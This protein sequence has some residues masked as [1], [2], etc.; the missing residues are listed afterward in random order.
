M[1]KIELTRGKY[2]LVDDAD[3]DFLMR[4][5]WYFNKGYAIRSG[6]RLEN[7]GRQKTI[8]M[9]RIINKTPEELLTDHANLDT[10]DNR[11]VNLR[12]ATRQQNNINK[13]KQQGTTSKYKGVYWV[14]RDKKW[15]VCIRANGRH[16]FLG[17]YKS[18]AEAARSYNE[19]ALK[20]HGD[21]CVLN[22]WKEKS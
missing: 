3:Y 18:E 5:K 21:F 10:L 7:A 1:K 2:A 15:R 19:A 16:I 20:Y 14:T 4:W 11:K 17:D 9:H 13:R 8:L 12:T 6:S 22:H